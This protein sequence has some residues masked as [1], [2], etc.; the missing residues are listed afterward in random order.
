MLTL[1][2]EIALQPPTHL[3]SIERRLPERG[4]HDW[5]TKDFQQVV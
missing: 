2:V 1:V 3:T 5:V 4:H